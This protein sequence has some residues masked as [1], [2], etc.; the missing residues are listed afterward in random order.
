MTNSGGF[1]TRF[2]VC[3]TTSRPL[4]IQSAFLDYLHEATVEELDGGDLS[5]EKKYVFTFRPQFPVELSNMI[6]K[7]ADNF[8]DII[9]YAVIVESSDGELGIALQM[10]HRGEI[11]TTIRERPTTSEA[12]QG[13]YHDIIKRV[14]RL[15][16]MVRGG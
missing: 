5:A 12:A 11:K 2:L 1:Q 15:A 7:C 8:R 3:L 13:V 9:K 6:K 4:S 16:N 10:D 14:A